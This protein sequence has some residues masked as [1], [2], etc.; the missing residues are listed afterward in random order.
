MGGQLYGAQ[1]SARAEDFIDLGSYPLDGRDPQRYS[2][3]LEGARAQLEDDGCCIL[4]G[5]VRGEMI[6][7][8]LP[9]KETASPSMRTGPSTGPTPISRR[10][11]R[12]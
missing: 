5:F 3:L 9:P 1:T 4:R 6:S 2:D 8:C 12:R 10:T 7:R 11:I